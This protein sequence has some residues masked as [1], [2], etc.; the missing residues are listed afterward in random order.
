MDTIGQLIVVAR[1]SNE[2][3]ETFAACGLPLAQDLE[4]PLHERHR[5]V[6]AVRH[7]EVFEQFRMGIEKI[8]VF[9]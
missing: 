9:F 3:S 5:P 4:L 6:A 1:D 8:R 7:M 2:F